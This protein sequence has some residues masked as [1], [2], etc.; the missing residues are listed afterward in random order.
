MSTCVRAELDLATEVE[1]GLRWL[2]AF[3]RRDAEA[4]VDIAHPRIAIH[5]TKLAGDGRPYCGH[6]GARRW[7]ADESEV[8]GSLVADVNEVRRG[9]S[10]DV[11]AFGRLLSGDNPV[12]PFSMLL[13]VRDGR[14]V[15]ARAYLSDRPTLERIGRIA[16]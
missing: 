15:Q 14:V 10:G 5:P 2:D 12:S 7:I 11:Y 4:L 1:L 13:S 3:N 6:D 9:P 16:T 8:A